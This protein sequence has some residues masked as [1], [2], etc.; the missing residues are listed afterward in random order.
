MKKCAGVAFVGLLAV[1]IVSGQELRK[2][3]VAVG[4]GFTQPTGDTGHNLD[5]G[6]NIRGGVGYNF[7]PYVGAMVDVGFNRM[8]ISGPTLTDLG[9]PGGDVQIFTATLDPIVHLNP[10]GRADLY[11]TGGGGLYHWYQEFT[12]PSVAVVRVFNPFFGFFRTVIPTTD[13]LSSYSVNKPGVNIGG[14]I[15]FGGL[16]RGKFFAEARWEHIYLTGSHADFV[17]VTFGFRW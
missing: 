11:V 10:R 5:L 2:L 1:A 4:G 17:P 16:R 7:T 13:V 8:G 14:G 15:A 9:V 6:W 12:A 3:S